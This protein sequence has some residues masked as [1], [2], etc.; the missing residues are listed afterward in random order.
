MK[1]IA[2]G[3]DVSTFQKSIDWGKVK[4]DG[5][6]FAMLRGG[7]GRYEKDE[8]FEANYKNAKKAGVPVGVYHYSYADTVNKAIQE[9]NFTLSYLKGKQLEYPIAFDI[10]EPSVYQLS[11]PLVTSIIKA[12]CDTVAAAGYCV[13][14]YSNKNWLTTKIDVKNIGG[15]DI[16]LAQYNNEVTY[17]GTYTMWQYSSKG[18]VSGIKSRVDMNYSYFDYPVYIKKK[19]LNGFSKPSSSN[20]TLSKTDDKTTT[21]KPTSSTKIKAGDVVKI[22]GSKYYNG[23]VIPSWVKARQ[24]VVYS[25]SGD[26]VIINQD[27]AKQ[28]AI[29]SPVKIKDV[30]LVSSSSTTTTKPSTNT[31]KSNVIE[32]GDVVKITG[33]YYYNSKNK[34]PLWVRLKQWVVFSISGNRIVID[35]DVNGKNAIMSPIARGD[36]KLVR[37]GK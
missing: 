36:L 8:T 16:W 5:I 23:A 15:Y 22:T 34:I 21:T 7:Y 12:Y 9:A 2:K 4:A 30:T 19:G 27:R 10:E 11:K 18:S 14:L 13:V 6:G 24:W 3:I 29:M 20:N 25:V 31:S 17:K 37:K 32:V 33:K 1:V 35:K 28:Y 26:K